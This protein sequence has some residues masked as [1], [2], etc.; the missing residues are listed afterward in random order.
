MERSIPCLPQNATGGEPSTKDD[1][2]VRILTLAGYIQW[3]GDILNSAEPF[4]ASG[5][6]V[7]A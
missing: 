2:V 3:H 6:G 5:A 4:A 7:S 1:M